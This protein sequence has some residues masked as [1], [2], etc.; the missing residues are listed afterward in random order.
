MKE[1]FEGNEPLFEGLAVHDG[2]DWSVRH[3]VLR[4]SFGGGHFRASGGLHANVMA[5]LDAGEAGAG[6]SSDYSTA[7][8]RFR[9]LLAAVHRRAGRRVVVLI[10]EYDKPILDVLDA[11]D[12]ARANRDYL[13]SVYAVVKDSVAA[14]EVETA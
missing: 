6:V 1:L 11:P 3:P 7:P 8:E 2:W 4:L 12:L 10:D 5:Q 9:S 13:R 14:F